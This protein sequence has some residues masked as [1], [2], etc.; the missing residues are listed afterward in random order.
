MAAGTRLAQRDIDRLGD[1]SEIVD[2]PE[3]RIRGA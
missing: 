2:L 3:L 1:I